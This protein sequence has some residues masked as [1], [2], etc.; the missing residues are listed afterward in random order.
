MKHEWYAAGHPPLP[1]FELATFESQMPAH[2]KS[3]REKGPFAFRDAPPADETGQLAAQFV[4]LERAGIPSESI[5]SSY[6]EANFP[7]A[8]AKGIDPSAIWR[9]RKIRLSPLPS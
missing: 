5:K 3:L 8:Q 7:D 1:S 9:E 4:T 2:W 6:K